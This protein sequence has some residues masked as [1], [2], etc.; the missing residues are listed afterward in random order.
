[1]RN[2]WAN[3]SSGNDTHRACSITMWRNGLYCQVRP[4]SRFAVQL[5]GS[6]RSKVSSSHVDQNLDNWL[7]YRSFPMLMIKR[8]THCQG[9]A[10]YPFVFLCSSETN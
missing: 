8:F 7:A 9:M 1:M 6:K 3:A 4:K 10:A 2:P 5:V